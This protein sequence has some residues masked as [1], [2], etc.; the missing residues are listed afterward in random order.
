VIG[1]LFKKKNGQVS[2]EILAILGVLIIGSIV[3][4]SFYISNINKKT[5]EV[6]NLSDSSDSFNDW[7]NDSG[8]TLNDTNNGNGVNPDDPDPVCGNNVIETGEV[9]DGTDLGGASCNTVL[10]G[11]NGTLECNSN[12]LSYDVTGCD[13]SPSTSY[14]FEIIPSSGLGIVSENYNG[15][16]FN[17]VMNE[18]TSVDVSVTVQKGFNYSDDCSIDGHLIPA[19]LVGYNLGTYI[20]DKDYYPT[21][22]CSGIGTYD[23]TF[24]TIDNNSFAINRTFTYTTMSSPASGSGAYA[25]CGSSTVGDSSLSFCV[26]QFNA[27]TTNS[28]GSLSIFVNQPDNA[29]TINTS[30]SSCTTNS[31][32]ELCIFVG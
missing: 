9:C 24:K 5:D 19:I 4:A 13:G 7:L 27:L 18:S 21:L 28:S 25:L 32:G 20:A 10:S 14:T 8:G 11:S 23:F 22:S 31:S 15:M 12:C 16:D 2:I 30:S 1:L 26:N 6:T 29:E 3:L 17:L